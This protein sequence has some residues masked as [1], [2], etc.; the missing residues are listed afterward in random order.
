MALALIGAVFL[1]VTASISVAIPLGLNAFAVPLVGYLGHDPFPSKAVPL[2]SFAWIVLAIAFFLSRGGDPRL[3]RAFRSP[4]VLATLALL[5]LLLV[6]LPASTDSSYGTFKVEL[7][8]ISNLTLLIAGIVLALRP[9]DINLFL[10]LALAIDAIS[11]LLVLRQFGTPGT[12]SSDRFG[13]AQQ[14]TISLGIQGAEG[15]IVA[16]YLLMRGTRRW[17]QMFGAAVLPV[18]FVALLASG[19]RGPVLGGVVGLLI[20]LAMLARSK[21]AVLRLALF[22]VLLVGSF[23]IAL[24]FVPA[25][26][27]ARSLST[28]TG[29]RSGLA[30]NGRDQL[31]A[32]AWTTFTEH[33]LIGVGTGSFATHGR[34]QVCPGPGCLDKYPHNVLLETAAELGIGG[35]ILMIVIL[36]A[37]ARG[38]LRAWRIPGEIGDYA[39]VASALFVSATTTALLT[40]DLSGDGGIWFTGGLGL[41]LC[42]AAQPVAAKVAQARTPL[43]AASAR[44]PVRTAS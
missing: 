21:Q 38:L 6:R 17:H 43:R 20:L 22:T 4:L 1:T 2:I 23:A 32:A 5:A 11:G 18:A 16:T 42:L 8:I 13:L 35:A 28:I 3:A 30:S 44:N 37:A 12:A 40:G 36:V 19:S 29:T 9:R 14:N 25:A 15:L 31:W 24:Q 39:T 27:S 7:F 41:G 34:T 33:P 26:A 10:V